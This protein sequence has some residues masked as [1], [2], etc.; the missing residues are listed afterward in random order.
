M[1]TR[2]MKI[3]RLDMVPPK[4]WRRTTTKV[5]KPTKVIEIPARL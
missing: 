5:E 3:S 2:V 1:N 4:V